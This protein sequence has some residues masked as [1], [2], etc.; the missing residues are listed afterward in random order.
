MIIVNLKK[1]CTHLGE[2]ERVAGDVSILYQVGDSF[3]AR[4]MLL[5]PRK[6]H[7]CDAELGRLKS[8]CL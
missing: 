8:N 7:I 6:S 5:W 2:G 3:S 4:N 1:T